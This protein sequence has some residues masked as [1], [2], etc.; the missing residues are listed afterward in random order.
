[1]NEYVGP[2]LRRKIWAIDKDSNT[3]TMEVGEITWGK[4][5]VRR[6][7]EGSKQNSEG[8]SWWKMGSCSGWGGGR[9][10]RSCA[11][12]SE[13]RKRHFKEERQGWTC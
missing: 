5:G 7:I 8:G 10:Q 2:K 6:K 9:S 1:M 4:S 13:A 12:L 3:K 11:V